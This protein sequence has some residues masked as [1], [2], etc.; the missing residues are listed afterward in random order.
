MEFYRKISNDKLIIEYQIKNDRIYFD[1]LLTKSFR[2]IRFYRQNYLKFHFHAGYLREEMEQF[3][4]GAYIDKVQPFILKLEDLVNMY[5]EAEHSFGEKNRRRSN[6]ANYI[7]YEISN[8]VCRAEAFD[9]I[10]KSLPL[11]SHYF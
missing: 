3:F 8:I 1:L 2:H 4:N 9:L 7:G 6:I 5:Y 10:A 11:K